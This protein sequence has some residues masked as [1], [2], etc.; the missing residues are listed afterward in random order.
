MLEGKRQKQ[1]ASVLEKELNNIF[2]KL[3]LTMLGGGMVSIASV[4]I[5][6]DLHEA[7]IYLSFFN[8]KDQEGTLKFIL[9]KNWEIKKMLTSSIRHQ[10]RTMPV[11]NY[12]IDDSLEYADKMETLFRELKNNETDQK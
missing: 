11:L 2:Q 12:Y 9:D 8:I 3:G 10:L 4:K 6:P 1:V 5:T 7:K